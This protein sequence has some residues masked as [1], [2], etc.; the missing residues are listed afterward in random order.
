MEGVLKGL[1]P[2]GFFRKR[3]KFL[4]H[5]ELQIKNCELCGGEF[6]VL[7]VE[8][9]MFCSLYHRK[10]YLEK[11][12]LLTDEMKIRLNI[13]HPCDSEYRGALPNGQTVRP[14]MGLF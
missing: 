7:R 6:K 4:P 14:K 3:G 8:D 2:G 9:K 11:S 12:G 13:T 1:I 10:I 5:Y